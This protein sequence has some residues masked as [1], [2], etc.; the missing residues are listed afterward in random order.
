M[1]VTCL[2]PVI[3][4]LMVSVCLLCNVSAYLHG[5]SLPGIPG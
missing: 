4:T 5:W 3:A 2:I 1:S